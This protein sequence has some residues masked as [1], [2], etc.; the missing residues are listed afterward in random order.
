MEICW[1]YSMFFDIELV[2]ISENIENFKFHKVIKEDLEK[3]LKAFKDKEDFLV[4]KSLEGMLFLEKSY[5][6]G[7]IYT[8]H[9]II[10]PTIAQENVDN[11]TEV[12]KINIK[13]HVFSKE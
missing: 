9:A 2:D 8:E 4:F 10:K 11:S 13:K 12:S 1:G 6:R 5:F 3:I 7:V